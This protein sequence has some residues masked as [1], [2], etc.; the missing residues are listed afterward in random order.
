MWIRNVFI[1]IVALRQK[2]ASLYTISG[3]LHLVLL[4]CLFDLAEHLLRLLRCF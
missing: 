2:A 4:I 1:E 3:S